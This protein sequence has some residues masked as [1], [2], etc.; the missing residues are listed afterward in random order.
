MIFLTWGRSVAICRGTTGELAETGRPAARKRER[1]GET[2]RDGRRG[3]GN[4]AQVANAGEAAGLLFDGSAD[5]GPGD[6]GEYGD[7]Q[8]GERCAFAAVAIQTRGTG[9]VDQQR[10]A[11]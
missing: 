8:R 4:P 3:E 7:F 2:K 9:G 6:R 5:A 11:A 10:A 1:A